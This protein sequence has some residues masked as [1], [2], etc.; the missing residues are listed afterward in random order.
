MPLVRHPTTMILELRLYSKSVVGLVVHVADR[1]DGLTGHIW[2][3]SGTVL[4][5]VSAGVCQDLCCGD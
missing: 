5:L 2:P 3:K 4:H 1:A